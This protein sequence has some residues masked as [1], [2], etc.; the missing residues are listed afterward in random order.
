MI[1]LKD[2]IPDLVVA[3]NWKCAL[4]KNWPSIVGQLALRMRI[5]KIQDNI[6]ILGVYEHC[7]L[8]ELY[9]LS[10]VIVKTI[11]THLGG[12][13]IKNV[14]LVRASRKQEKQPTTCT[15]VH[16]MESKPLTDAQKKALLAIHDSE[17]QQALKK[18]FQKSKDGK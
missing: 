15:T 1:A 9:V 5:E 4:L 6:L 3:D 13:Y 11:N 8:Q 14:R 17:L 12:H 7:W 16:H 10:P 2:L 18:C